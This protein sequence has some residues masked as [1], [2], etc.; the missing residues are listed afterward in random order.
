MSVNQEVG[1]AFSL[2]INL[3]VATSHMLAKKGDQEV[4]METIALAYF[5]L[6]WN[7]RS[8]ITL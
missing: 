7:L 2:T 5:T 4:G 1:P 8:M 3:G 6:P